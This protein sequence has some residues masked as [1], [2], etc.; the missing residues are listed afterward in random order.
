MMRMLLQSCLVLTCDVTIESVEA[1]AP[2]R[3]QYRW[4]V[5]TSETRIHCMSH[6]GDEVRHAIFNNTDREA[7]LPDEA[8]EGE[9]AADNSE[10]ESEPQPQEG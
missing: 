3:E 10:V 2:V 6:F 1:C 8:V 7:A 5:I 4:L 9:D